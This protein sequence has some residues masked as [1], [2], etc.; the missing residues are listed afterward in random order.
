MTNAEKFH[1]VFGMYA[2]EIWSLPEA[3]FLKWLNEAAGTDSIPNLLEDGTLVVPVKEGA[4]VGRVLIEEEGTCFGS[5]FYPD[6]QGTDCI[7][8]GVD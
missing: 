4:K 6:G 8:E 7:G 3:D 2:T 5:M 1:A